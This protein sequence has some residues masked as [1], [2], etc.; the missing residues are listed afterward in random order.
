MK[1]PEKIFGIETEKAYE[2]YLARSKTKKPKPRTPAN[3]VRPPAN[4]N[5]RDYIRIPGTNTLIAREETNKGLN[6]D[7]THFTL[8]DSGLYMPSQKLFMPYFLNVIEAAKGNTTLYDGANNPIPRDEA[9]DLYKY[10]TSGHR[11]GC[12]TW[13]D[14]K[15]EKE[16]SSWFIETDH[17]VAQGSTSK[18]RM[19]LE[20]CLREDAYVELDF[21]SQGLAT[22]KSTDQDYKQGEN[23]YYW[24]PRDGTVA[25]FNAGSGWADLIC[26]RDPSGSYAELGVFACA[27]GTSKS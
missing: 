3:P 2:E 7:D 6:W 4:I 11:D 22:K 9:E 21:N 10:L 12:W 17:R 1:L 24:H 20:A 26:G 27:E 8:Q 13:L 25:R 18:T 14:A 23:I 5:Q 19:P 15:F 16:G